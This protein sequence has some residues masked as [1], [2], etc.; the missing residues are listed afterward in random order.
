MERR[1]RRRKSYSA[2][3][4]LI[5]VISV[6]VVL[7]MIVSFAVMFMPEPPQPPPPTSTATGLTG[8]TTDATT[9]GDAAPAGAS[10]AIP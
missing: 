7:S 4:I 9:P 8:P 3:Q 10:T 5:W 2:T 6:L 1:T